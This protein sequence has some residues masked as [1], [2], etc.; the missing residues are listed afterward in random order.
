MKIITKNKKAF[1]DYEI[2]DRL[3]AGIVLSGDEVK[4]IRSGHISLIGSF[5]HEREGEFY[6]VN[7]HITPYAQA[8]QKKDDDAARSRKLLLH[9]K[10]ID[11]LL[12]KVS[13]QGITIVPLSVYLNNKG[14]V[15]VELG[16]AKHKKAAGKKAALK[17]RDIKRETAR[18]IKDKYKF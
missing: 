15:K 9:K 16:L 17:E 5:A 10:E 11:Q 13:R 4:S 12:G 7:A 14:L 2:L 3:E 8:Y 6:L 1:F 18:E